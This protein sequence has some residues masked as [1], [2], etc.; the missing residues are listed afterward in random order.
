MNAVSPQPLTFEFLKRCV[1]ETTPAAVT[2]AGTLEGC[3]LRFGWV[4]HD[5]VIFEAVDDPKSVV[6]TFCVDATVVVSFDRGNRQRCFLAYVLAV[7][8]T[9]MV[10]VS[11]P[12][13]V[14]ALDRRRTTR[15]PAQRQRATVEYDGRCLPGTV[16]DISVR[17]LGLMLDLGPEPPPVGATLDVTLQRGSLTV[18]AH[19]VSVNGRRCGLR[20][21]RADP[22]LF[23]AW[24]RGLRAQGPQ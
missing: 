2:L 12:D 15:I 18:L 13:Q 22:D 17:G 21:E 1:V 11:V 16:Q 9:G 24:V 3:M 5:G 20:V 4:H 23:L 7:E 8:P 14:L 19:V 6:E 10:T